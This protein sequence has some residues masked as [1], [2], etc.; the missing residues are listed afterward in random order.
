[1]SM[2]DQALDNIETAIGN[3]HPP[4][5]VLGALIVM[6]QL[7]SDE[8]NEV[9]RDALRDYYVY[10]PGTGTFVDG[11]DLIRLVSV[12]DY[13]WDDAEAEFALLDESERKCAVCL[14][15][16]PDDGWVEEAPN[17]RLCS[18]DC[19]D[20]YSNGTEPVSCAWYPA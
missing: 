2:R 8:R 20:T 6:R 18:L 14:G 9:L 10:H 3:V 15:D 5:R 19:A 4:D 7:D 16:R 13:E 1:M 11:G 12:H 17:F